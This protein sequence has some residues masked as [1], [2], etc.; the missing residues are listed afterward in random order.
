M[1]QDLVAN[2]PNYAVVSVLGC[3]IFARTTNISIVVTHFSAEGTLWVCLYAL[4]EGKKRHFYIL[5][6]VFLAFTIPIQILQG[7]ATMTQT[8]LP[9]DP[10]TQ[11]LGF[12]CSFYPP[13][14]MNLYSIATYLAVARNL[15]ALILG[16]Y[17]FTVRYRKQKN[18]LIRVI[19]REGGMYFLSTLILK[20]FEA[21]KATPKSP[22]KDKYTII[23]SLNWLCVNVFAERLLLLLKKIDHPGTQAVV[24][25]LM[26]AGEKTRPTMEIFE[27]D[28]QT[29]SEDTVGGLSSRVERMGEV[30]SRE[31]GLAPV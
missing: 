29:A 19:K 28:S 6:L 8:A 17:T 3:E 21:L 26:F 9:L 4:M 11:A 23:W 16:M 12:P 22:I 24:S 2:L 25:E 10:L 30:K 14:H 31:P 15:V 27:E 18:A 5:V 1:A 13:N 7:F 20:F